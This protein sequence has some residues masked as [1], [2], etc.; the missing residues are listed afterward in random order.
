M[1][2][3]TM[4]RSCR[5]MN[6]RLQMFMLLRRFHYMFWISDL[7]YGSVGTFFF[8]VLV[9]LFCMMFVLKMTNEMF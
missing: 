9:Y 5:P 8:F 3:F 2:I 6:R 4:N 7:L 1:Q